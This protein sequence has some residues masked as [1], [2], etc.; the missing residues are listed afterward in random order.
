MPRFYNVKELPDWYE[1]N[2]YDRLLSVNSLCPNAVGFDIQ[3]ISVKSHYEFITLPLL[4]LRRIVFWSRPVLLICFLVFCPGLAVLICWVPTPSIISLWRLAWAIRPLGWLCG[5][6]IIILAVLMGVCGCRLTRAIGFLVLRCGGVIIILAVLMGRM[7]IRVIPLRIIR[8]IMVISPPMWQH[9]DINRA[10]PVII[11]IPTI[12]EIIRNATVIVIR[13]GS[14]R[15]ISYRSALIN[16][17]C[18]RD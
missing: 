1:L 2:L 16:D 8:V 11:A 7:K 13:N 14:I 12:D 17:R 10:C 5:R 3:T 4:T 18:R 15:L 9:V 6:V